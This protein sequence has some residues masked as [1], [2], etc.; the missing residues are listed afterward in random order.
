[1]FPMRQ[2]L[3]LPLVLVGL[4]LSALGA[5]L[6]VHL[7]SNLP[8]P[9]AVGTPIGLKPTVEDPGKGMIVCQYS[10]SVNGGPFRVVP[11]FGQRAEF[12]RAPELFEQDAT[13]RVTARNDETKETAEDVLGFRV[14]PQAKG[15]LRLM[16]NRRRV[17][18]ND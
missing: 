14:V 9:Q 2:L 4:C 13:V 18:Y 8:S 5:A 1:M 16:G 12:A 7:R 6:S 10:A 11:G 15:T 17:E 3:G